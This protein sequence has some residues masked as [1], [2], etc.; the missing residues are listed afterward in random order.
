M[1]GLHSSMGDRQQ[2]HKTLNKVMYKTYISSGNKCPKE[3]RMG[4]DRKEGTIFHV[5]VEEASLIR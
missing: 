3:G 2:P 5:M 1:G 4:K